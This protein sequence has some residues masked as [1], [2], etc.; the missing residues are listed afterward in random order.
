[1]AVRERIRATVPDARVGGVLSGLAIGDQSAIDREDWDVFRLTGVSHLV[2]ISGTHVAMFGWLAAGLLKLIWVRVGFFR[3]SVSW[4]TAP[5]VARIGGVL[6]AFAYAML[7]GWGVPAQRTVVMMAAFGALRMAGRQWPWPLVLLGSAVVVTLWDPWSCMQAGFWLSFVAVAVLMSQGSD[8][9]VSDNPLKP[10]VWQRTKA[11]LVEMGVTQWRVS[12]GL[13]PLSLVFFQQTSLVGLL[14]NLWAIPVFTFVI[15]PLALVGMVISPL[16]S[17]GAHVVEW[18]LIALAWLA[19]WPLAT[20]QAPLLPFWAAVCA[21][22][23]GAIM[24]MPMRWAWR[25]AGLPFLLPLVA[26]P[27]SWHWW[28]TPVP[29]QFSVL[30]AD[31]GQGTSVL[32]RTAHHALLFDAG[33]K[34]GLQSDAGARVVAPLLRAAGVGLLDTVMISHADADHVGGAASVYKAVAVGQLRSSLDAA[35]P[36][37]NTADANGQ[38]PPHHECVAGQSWLWDGVVFRVLRPT[39]QDL[40][41]RDQLGDNAVSCVLQIEAKAT[42]HGAGR[43]ALLT[44]DIESAQ[45]QQLVES[46][47]PGALRADLLVVPHHGSQTSSTEPFLDAVKPAMSVMQVGKRNRYGHPSP[48]VLNR[49]Q[50]MGLPFVATPTCGAFLWRSDDADRTGV[51]WREH[52]HRYWHAANKGS[53]ANA[54]NASQD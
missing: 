49:Y 17:V 24:L 51:C 10:T 7:A 37:L 14:A 41:R 38:V 18:S 19:H 11:G 36:L 44:G 12:L 48:S 9:G 29:G 40:D 46:S 8:E 4:L 23:A 43:R 31:V 53:A 21:V 33:P 1:M 16:W 25:L 27:A 42:G 45:E 30:A 2:S 13:A 6:A 34:V 32:V 26:M 28:P 20:V 47:P 50:A 39:Q 54:I 3:G 52:R 22:M 35:H 15:T 5:D